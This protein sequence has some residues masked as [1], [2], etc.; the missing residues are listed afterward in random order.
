MSKTTAKGNVSRRDN[1]RIFIT[2]CLKYT[3]INKCQNYMCRKCNSCRMLINNSVVNQSNVWHIIWCRCWETRDSE[4]DFCVGVSEQSID[5]G[6]IHSWNNYWIFF[7]SHFYCSFG[8]LICIYMARIHIFV[9]RS[10]KYSKSV[11]K[12]FVHTEIF[13]Y[14]TEINLYY[15]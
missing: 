2:Y 8:H 15:I 7:P 10:K 12:N 14:N 4:I 3:P 5:M 11:Y 13:L 9:Y 6:I 1:S